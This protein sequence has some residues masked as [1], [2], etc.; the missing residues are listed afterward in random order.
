MYA[1][2]RSSNQNVIKKWN[3]VQRFFILMCLQLVFVLFQILHFTLLHNFDFVYPI[4]FGFSGL[5]VFW[6]CGEM[7]VAYLVGWSWDLILVLWGKSK[8]HIPSL[9]FCQFH[10]SIIQLWDFPIPYIQVLNWNSHS[11]HSISR[12]FIFIF[13]FHTSHLRF[14]CQFHTSIVQLWNFPI[15]YIQMLDSNSHFIHSIFGV[16]FWFHT[17]NL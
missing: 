17:S 13:G 16:F 10:T 8:P 15:P 2:P 7:K 4:F 1:M 6:A 3:T 9:I 11:I 5:R 14:F 12:F